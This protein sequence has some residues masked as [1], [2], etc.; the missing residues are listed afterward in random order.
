MEHMRASGIQH[1]QGRYIDHPSPNLSY[2][3]GTG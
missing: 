1:A 2:T 3:L